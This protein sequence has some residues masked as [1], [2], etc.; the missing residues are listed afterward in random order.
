MVEG[1]ITLRSSY[2]QKET[3]DRLVASVASHGMAIFARVDHAAAA[4]KIN[5]EL[6]PTEVLIFGNPAAGTLLMQNTRSIGID[7]PL[8]VLVSQDENATTWI[9]YQDIGSLAKRHGLT[10]NVQP[11]VDKMASLIKVVVEEAAG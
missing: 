5:L 2:A 11:T 6:R 3:V 7:L 1:L 9:S 8:K 4:A 10:P